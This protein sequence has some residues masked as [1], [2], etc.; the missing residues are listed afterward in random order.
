MKKYLVIFEKTNTGYS[1]YSPD[2]E[3]CIATGRTRQDVEKNIQEAIVFH[4][5]GLTIEGY[6]TPQSRSYSKYM[7]V[8]A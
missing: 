3:G 6:V 5:E 4:I 7:E 1:A 8:A 2:I